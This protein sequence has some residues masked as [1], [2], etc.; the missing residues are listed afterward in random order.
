MY[1]LKTSVILIKKF[2]FPQ[3]NNKE[4]WRISADIVS[5]KIIRFSSPGHYSRE[6]PKTACHICYLKHSFHLQNELY[7]TCSLSYF[8]NYFTPLG[9]MRLTY[10]KLK[11]ITLSYFVIFYNKLQV[12]YLT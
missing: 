3:R 10:I 4:N 6:F 1:L 12:N 9:N 8:Q 2:F 11:W 7:Y 5:R